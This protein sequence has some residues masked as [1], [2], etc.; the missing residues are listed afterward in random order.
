MPQVLG[1]TLFTVDVENEAFL[2]ADA[3][4]VQVPA[5]LT[6]ERCDRHAL[7]ESKTSATFPVFA[8]V[9][10]AEPVQLTVTPAAPGRV[11]LQSLLDASC[12]G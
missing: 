5:V 10:G 12:G 9:D 3:D 2:G 8:A 7:I 6:A 4:A 11:A 1:S